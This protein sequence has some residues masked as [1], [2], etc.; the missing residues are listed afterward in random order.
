MI[1][2]LISVIIVYLHI[3]IAEHEVLQLFVLMYD[4]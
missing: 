1:I 2:K 3:E 4:L